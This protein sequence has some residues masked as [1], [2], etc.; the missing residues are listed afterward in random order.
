ML[1]KGLATAAE[2]S[3]KSKGPKSLLVELD[4]RDKGQDLTG[5]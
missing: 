2:G 5:A 3:G 1:P 4:E